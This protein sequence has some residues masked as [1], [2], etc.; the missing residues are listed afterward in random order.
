[1]DYSVE[2]EQYL[3]EELDYCDSRCALCQELASLALSEMT[4][5]QRRQE[6][7]LADLERLRQIRRLFSL[8]KPPFILE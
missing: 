8:Q 6:Q 5:L 1:M 4:E 3:R 2:Y 7:L